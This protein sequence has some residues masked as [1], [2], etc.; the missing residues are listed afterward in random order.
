MRDCGTNQTNRLEVY[1]RTQDYVRGV[2]DAYNYCK[3]E[4]DGKV[5][6]W[7]VQRLP[8]WTG[9]RITVEELSESWKREPLPNLKFEQLLQELQACQLLLAS[10]S[11]SHFQLWLPAWGTVLNAWEQARK[12]L[13]LQLKSSSYKERSASSLVQKHSPIPSRLLMKWMVAQGQIES[14]EK[15]S[16]MFLRLLPA[17]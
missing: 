14:V 10:H 15:P 12:K 6:E 17:K 7:F 13:L 5:V 4:I 11:S 1:L 3:Q 16:G 8:D 9:R 2:W